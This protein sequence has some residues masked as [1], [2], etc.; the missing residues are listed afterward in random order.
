MRALVGR[1]PLILLDE[2]WSGMDEIM[3]RVAREYLRGD[4]SSTS[5][6]PDGGGIGSDQAVVVVTHWEEEVPWSLDEDPRVFKRFRLGGGKGLRFHAR[7]S[8][9][10][11]KAK[12]LMTETRSTLCCKGS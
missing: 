8:G 4:P 7:F 9:I 1:A 12:R 10:K 11:C 6:S 3:V 5:T 2:V